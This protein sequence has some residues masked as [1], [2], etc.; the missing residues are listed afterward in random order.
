MKN[1]RIIILII[2]LFFSFLNLK[3]L[4]KDIVLP[5]PSFKS[6]KNFEKVLRNRRTKRIYSERELNKLILSQLLWAAQGIS[7]ENR[8]FR[9]APSA[10]ALY[11]LEIY[12]IIQNKGCKE[13]VNGLYRYIPE[14][15]RIRLIKS[16]NLSSSL[17]E[18]GYS[19]D[20]FS[21]SPICFIIT[22]VPIRTT[23][24]YGERGYRYIYIEVGHV[25]QNIQLQGVSLGLSVGIA[26]AFRDN[27]LKNLL[28]L[29]K[30]EIPLYL[31]PVGY[32]K[33]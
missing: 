1:I 19:Q 28:G 10:G 7:D 6:D 13:L 25:G 22:A 8:K 30:N 14:G 11:P 3:L 9:T 18:V 17:G 31:M 2:V 33:K 27:K 24:K 32:P 23:K 20:F 29:D 15:H 4:S 26:G 12:F 5:G 21:E 16:G